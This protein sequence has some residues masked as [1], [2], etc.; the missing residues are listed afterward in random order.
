MSA[1]RTTGARARPVVT[2]AVTV[3]VVVVGVFLAY[4]AN[5]GLPL[6]PHYEVEALVDDAADLTK[7]AEVREGGARVGIVSGLEVL[8]PA[9]GDA[10]SARLELEL[11][12]G[13]GPLPDDSSVRIRP[14]SALGLAYVELRRGTSARRVA[15]GGVL[16]RRGGHASTIDDVLSDFTAPERRVLRRNLRGYGDAFA[17]RGPALNEAVG[18]L[19]PFFADLRDVGVAVGR[20]RGAVRRLIGGLARFNAELAPVADAAAGLLGGGADSFAALSRDPRALEETVVRS[21]PAARAT[22]RALS[23]SAPVLDDLATLSRQLRATTRQLPAALP[24]LRRAF[25]AGPA[26]LRDTERIAPALGDALKAVGELARRPGTDAAL[27]GLGSTLGILEPTLRFLVPYQTVC[28]SWNSL[29]TLLAEHLSAEDAYG[30]AERIGLV[31]SGS[32]ANSFD[33]MGATEPANGPQFAHGQPFGAA[34]TADG[35]ADCE[36][37]QRGYLKGR[38]SK[39]TDPKLNVV[40][41]PRTPG[42]QG[43]TYR[44]RPRVPAGQPFSA[45]PTTGEQLPRL[46]DTNVRVPAP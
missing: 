37:G 32:Q 42:A 44:G 45:E 11:G 14:R 5:R 36:Q 40:S 24:P 27:R 1:R 7:G 29:W 28:N 39:G 33:V 22:R 20:P 17:G 46:F 18:A 35:A 19:P 38:L 8:R 6:V 25:A 23:V 21:G 13:A 15:G 34:V 31:F 43:P 41:D 4:N 16:P 9:D 30:Y 3:L 10:V 12:R 2:G 26:P